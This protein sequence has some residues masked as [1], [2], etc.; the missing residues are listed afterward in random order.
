[1]YQLPLFVLD[2]TASLG[3]LTD[4]PYCC[5]YDVFGWDGAYLGIAYDQRNTT[6]ATW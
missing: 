3:W 6:N 1:M 5:I 4:G 2:N